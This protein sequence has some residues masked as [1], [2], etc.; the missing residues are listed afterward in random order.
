MKKKALFID[1]DG[2]LIKEPPVTFQVDTLEQLEFMPGVLRNLYRIKRDM[3][4]ELVMVT[5]QDG[6]GT[7]AYPFDNFKTVQDKMLQVFKGEGIV[8]DAIFIDDSFEK[9]NKPTRKPGTGMLKEY[10]DGNYDL[11]ESWVI[12]DRQTDM[13]LAANLG[14]QAILFD[15]TLED[16]GGS[17]TCDTAACWDDVYNI[18]KNIQRK[19]SVER[20]TDETAIKVSLNPDGAGK[21]A[22]QTGVHFFDHMLQQLAKHGNMDIEIQVKGDLWIDE[23]HTIEDTGIVLGQAFRKALRDKRGM[24]R[25]GFCLPMDDCLAQVSVDFGGRS[26]LVWEADFHRER[27]GDMPTEMFSH[28]FKSFSESAACNLNIKAEGTNEHHKIE[29]IFKAF[30]RAIKMAVHCSEDNKQ[31]PST[32]G[33]L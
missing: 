15:G 26:W 5:N 17:Y 9:D 32:K 10:M 4:Y 29:S 27:I 3:G 18:L 16:T 20:I 24:E 33:V 23:H 19:V 6:L 1:R 12:G 14:A 21:S 7:A 8:F 31:L 28:F 30:G 25:Y 2:T 22:I 11:S 13:L